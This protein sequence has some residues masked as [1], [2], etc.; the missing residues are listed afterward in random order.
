LCSAAIVRW[1][2]NLD[3]TPFIEHRMVLFYLPP[4]SPELNLIEIVWK[5]AMY[6]WRRFVTW[7]NEPLNAEMAQLL[8]DFGSQFQID[9]S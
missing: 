9:F 3:G 1:R 4:Y 2:P 7:T 6:H 8:A 5:H